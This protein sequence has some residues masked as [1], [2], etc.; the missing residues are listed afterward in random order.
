[1]LTFVVLLVL[2]VGGEGHQVSAG[3]GAHQRDG[4]AV[5]A[6]GTLLPLAHVSQL[7]DGSLERHSRR[8]RRSP[9]LKNMK[10]GSVKF[11]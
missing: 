6:L 11:T 8:A 1:M 10:D 3:P 5:G 7:H 9:H 4:G 2:Q